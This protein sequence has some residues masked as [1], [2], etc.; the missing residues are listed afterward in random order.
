MAAITTSSFGDFLTPE[1]SAPIFDKVAELST[2]QRVVQRVD[3]GPNGTSIPVFASDLT[4]GWVGENQAKPTTEAAP[5]MLVMEPK[6][7]A[8]IFVASAEVVRA[9]PA[10]FLVTMREKVASAFARAFDQAA[11]HGN[12]SA[13]S[14]YIDQTTQPAV[15]L[16][17]GTNAYLQLNEGLSELVA[18]GKELTGFLF[19]PRTEPILNGAVDTANRPLFIDTPITETNPTVRP[20][21]VLGRP[22]YIG[23]GVYDAATSVVGYGGDW[24]RAAWGVVGGISFDVSDQATVALD[25][26]QP[27]ALTSLW[28]NNLVAVRAEAEY[29]FVVADKDAFVKY[30]NVAGV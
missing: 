26:T 4:A 8:T 9:N 23:K 19:D 20:G 1:Q 2:V 7:L 24:S 3:L 11:L 22:A 30:T 13:F 27:N 25:A 5:T 17:Q 16:E 14:Y 18:D 12:A 29:G 10:N 15:S 28:Q 21:R 6:K